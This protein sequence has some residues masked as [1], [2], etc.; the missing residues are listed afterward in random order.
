MDTVGRLHGFLWEQV[1]FLLHARGR[2][3][4]N[5]T[6]TAPVLGR[7]GCVVVHDAQFM[8][9]RASHTLKSWLL[10]AGVTPCVARRYRTVVTVSRHARREI[11]DYD[12][13]RRDDIRVIANGVDHVL[14]SS[15]D[16]RLLDRW[17]L[18]PGG[19]ALANSYVH[20]HK[21]VRVL[22]QA[23]AHLSERPLVLFGSSTEAEFRER[24]ITVPANVRFLGRVS[25]AEL[26][27]L[28]ANARMFL[29]PSTTEGF[30][31]PPL[32]A[33]LLGCPA[34]CAKAGAL[35]ENCGDAVLYCDPHDA[36]GW[37]AQ[38]DA[39]WG[40]EAERRRLGE[41]GRAQARRFDWMDA[42][43]AYLDLIVAQASA[44]AGSVR[45]E[46][47]RHALPS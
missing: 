26:V 34:V 8:S 38:V 21:N 30:G 29:C 35:P 5:F 17:G 4:V 43:R 15:P 47:F 19:Y 18:A 33:M 24:G 16:P 37:Q 45:T 28:M 39:L 36:A 23:F 1:E 40:E 25:D 2:Y 27:A 3:S 13:C 11:L 31:L 32:E 42:A 12:V 46:R 22:L 9:S 20:A 6:N 14:R 44:R 41:A 10:Y 7:N